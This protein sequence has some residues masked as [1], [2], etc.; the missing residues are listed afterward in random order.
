[1]NRKMEVCVEK[2]NKTPTHNFNLGEIPRRVLPIILTQQV[3][4]AIRFSVMSPIRLLGQC[5]RVPPSTTEK[6]VQYF[7]NL[8]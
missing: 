5:Q 2:H 3:Q 6:T 7:L 4:R 1:M 8:I